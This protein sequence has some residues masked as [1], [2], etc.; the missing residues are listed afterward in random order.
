MPGACVAATG[1]YTLELLGTALVAHE[2]KGAES[3][4]GT[5]AAVIGLLA[6]F[7]AQAQ[8]TLYAAE[9][10]VVR[11]F[12]LWPRGLRSINNIP[13]TD[14]DRRAYRTY[15]QRQRFSTPDREH[16]DVTFDHEQT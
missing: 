9:I 12:R 10:N 4:Y 2:L 15:A 5:F 13:T 14:A 11:M 1:W 7:R 6:F 16:I 8:L 3:T